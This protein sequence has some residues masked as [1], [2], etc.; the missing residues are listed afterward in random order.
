MNVWHSI[1]AP[2]T[3]VLGRDEAAAPLRD[4][5]HSFLRHGV[6]VAGGSLAAAEAVLDGGFA[7]VGT[8]GPAGGGPLLSPLVKEAGDEDHGEE[9]EEGGADPDTDGD[10]DGDTLAG[11][12]GQAVHQGRVAPHLGGPLHQAGVLGLADLIQCLDGEFVFGRGFE[13]R[14]SERRVVDGI[15]KYNPALG[16]ETDGGLWVILDTV[17]LFASSIKPRLPSERDGVT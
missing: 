14:D 12:V 6:V 4:V 1:S 15:H 13:A 8:E 5:A 16:V 3:V 10:D 2:Q 7:V 11:G 9:E 17:H